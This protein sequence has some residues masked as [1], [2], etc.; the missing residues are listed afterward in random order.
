MGRILLSQL[1]DEE[2]ARY[3]ARAELVPHTRHTI[4]STKELAAALT[5]C[6]SL[7]WS[8]V[9][10]Q[11]E[12]GMCGIAVPILDTQGMAVAA[13]NVSLNAGPQAEEI[14]MTTILPKLRL[15]ARRLTTGAP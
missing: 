11:Y 13:L 3:L 15:A 12:E 8:F 4:T 6:R 2:L 10:E 9:S 7:G 5:D 14:A 1:P